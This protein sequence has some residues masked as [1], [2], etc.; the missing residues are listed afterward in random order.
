[1]YYFLS[2]DCIISMSILLSTTSVYVLWFYHSLS[3]SCILYIVFFFL[4]WCICYE[5]WNDVQCLNI[6]QCS[7][8]LSLSLL[9]CIPFHITFKSMSFCVLLANKQVGIFFFLLS[10]DVQYFHSASLYS[11]FYLHLVSSIMVWPE[12]HRF[13]NSWVF[14]W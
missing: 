4:L 14:A 6:P 5:L 12:S 8:S 10:N 1:M 2:I 3:E 9:I 13:P 11:Q 7:L